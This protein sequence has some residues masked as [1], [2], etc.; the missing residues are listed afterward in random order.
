[1]VLISKGYQQIENAEVEGLICKE[2]TNQIT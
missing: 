1:M 2:I